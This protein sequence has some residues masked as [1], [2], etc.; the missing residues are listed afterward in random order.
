MSAYRVP[1][2]VRFNDCLFMQ[3]VPLVEWHPP[4]CAGIL[5]ILVRNPQWGPKPFQPLYFEEF[6]NDARP[7]VL[8]PSVRRHD[9]LVSVLPMPF[10]T[11]AQR[12]ALRDEL[13][14]AYNPACQVQGPTSADLTRKVDQLEARQ[15]EQSQ[16]ILSLLTHLGKL[17]EPQPM[18]PRRQIGFLPQSAPVNPPPT[19]N[20]RPE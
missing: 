3:P 6:G 5:A 7:T 18:S 17:F 11:A 15:A 9:L 4:A 13:I 14:A 2:G 12:R 1:P 16:Q 10:S 19:E 8:P 20:A